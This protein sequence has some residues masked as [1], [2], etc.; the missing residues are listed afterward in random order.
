MKKINDLGAIKQEY[1]SRE[2]KKICSNYFITDELD[3]RNWRMPPEITMILGQYYNQSISNKISMNKIS[4]IP[5]LQNIHHVQ[6]LNN[7]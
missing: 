5:D 7:I 1:A 4:S 6:K 3:L 2:Y